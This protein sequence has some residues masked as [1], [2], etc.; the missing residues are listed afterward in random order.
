MALE[1]LAEDLCED[2]PWCP[3]VHRESPGIAIVTGTEVTDPEVLA[4][5]RVGPGERAVMLAEDILI[6]AVARLESTR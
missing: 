3:A 4:Q 6:T 1:L 2:D 5:L